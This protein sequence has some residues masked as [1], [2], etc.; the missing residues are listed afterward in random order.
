MF[1]SSEEVEKLLGLVRAIINLPPV[2]YTRLTAGK[3][4]SINGF[5]LFV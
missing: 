2:I 3:N 4:N 5:S 1:G